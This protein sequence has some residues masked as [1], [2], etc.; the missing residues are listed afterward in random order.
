MEKTIPM[1]SE[2]VGKKPSSK[3]AHARMDDLLG[4][5]TDPIIVYSSPWTDTLP[6]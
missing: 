3:E 5:L 1:F 4:A 2:I 6:E